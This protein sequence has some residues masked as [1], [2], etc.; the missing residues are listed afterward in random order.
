M[1]LANAQE[2]QEVGD[3]KTLV[4]L[5][6]DM[7]AW[8]AAFFYADGDMTRL[9]AEST[10]ASLCASS[11]R[12]NVQAGLSFARRLI[13]SP[14]ENIDF[15][16]DLLIQ[17]AD[18]WIDG[19]PS[20]YEKYVALRA[21]VRP[22]LGQISYRNDLSFVRHLLDSL[23]PAYKAGVERRAERPSYGRYDQKEKPASPRPDGS[24]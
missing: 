11:D 1:L 17:Y 19:L 23:R 9:I 5:T 8:D 24:L 21:V 22:L 6:Q 14:L 13:A 15:K 2:A 12:G 20:P 10:I 7:T 18:E 16:R 3:Q 4:S